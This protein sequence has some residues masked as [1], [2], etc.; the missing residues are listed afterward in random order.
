MTR[1]RQ[2][3]IGEAEDSTR[4]FK[5]D[6]RNPGSLAAKMAASPAAG[7]APARQPFPAGSGCPPSA[8]PRQTFEVAFQAGGGV[9]RYGVSG[10]VNRGA[11]NGG[12]GSA[13]NFRAR[14]GFVRREEIKLA[15]RLSTLGHTA[16][17]IRCQGAG[18][19]LM[20]LRD[21]GIRRAVGWKMPR[22]LCGRN[23]KGEFCLV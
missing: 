20:F 13:R 19:S 5:S 16:G 6:K 23:G 21:C 10:G 22:D 14:A 18:Y 3:E 7:S 12:G 11:G 4:Q 8:A 1:K 15:M 17:L 9:V 2:L